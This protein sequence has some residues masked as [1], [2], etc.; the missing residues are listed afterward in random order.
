M[1][2]N[3]NKFWV[4]Q[5]SFSIYYLANG[6]SSPSPASIALSQTECYTE[7][8]FN[9]I[10]RMVCAISYLLYIHDMLQAGKESH[11]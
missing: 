3:I 8:S 7:P 2:L 9:C 5:E 6:R 11:S 1:L 10:V 4:K